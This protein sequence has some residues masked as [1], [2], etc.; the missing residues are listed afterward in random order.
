MIVGNI[1]FYFFD[2]SLHRTCK[3]WSRS[4]VFKFHCRFFN[5]VWPFCG[6]QAKTKAP[7]V[8]PSAAAFESNISITTFQYCSLALIW[9][10]VLFTNGERNVPCQRENACMCYFSSF[11]SLSWRRQTP[12]DDYGRLLQVEIDPEAA[13]AQGGG[14]SNG[15]FA[16]HT[17]LTM[18]SHASVIKSTR[19]FSCHRVSQ[20]LYTC[21]SFISCF[22][23]FFV[24]LKV[25]PLG[26]I[27]H[28]RPLLLRKTKERTTKVHNAQPTR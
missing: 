25:S 6:F 9:L 16:F 19:S 10:Y 14:G 28:W 2:W 17:T 23:L 12:G 7:S 15:P 8:R 21:F 1:S 18:Q 4:K 22:H 5:G 26:L 20:G 3:H 13:V 11:F 27:K 24:F